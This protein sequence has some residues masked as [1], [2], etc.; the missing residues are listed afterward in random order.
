ME[1]SY[2]KKVQIDSDGLKNHCSG[3]LTG[4]LF[5][6]IKKIA[7]V[8]FKMANNSYVNLWPMLK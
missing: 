4:S 5:V 6:F 2:N 8:S 1:A 7:K 3:F